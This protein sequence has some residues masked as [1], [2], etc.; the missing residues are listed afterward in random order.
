[1]IDFRYHLVSIVAIFLALSVGIVLG[2]TLLKEPAI[3]AAETLAN[4]LREGNTALRDDLQVLQKRGAAN[5]ALIV[6][7]TPKLVKDEL[8]GK[9]VV[10]VEAPGTTA[11]MR[12]AVQQVILEAGATVTG[13]V[14]LA[15]RYVD[16][17]QSAFV[18]KLATAAKPAEMIFPVAGTAYD[19]AA[20]VLASA[21][22]TSDPAQVGKEDPAAAEVL[23][24][25]QRGGLLTVTDKPAEHADLAVLTAPAEP[26]VGET[27]AEQAIAAEQAG[28]IVAMA[29]GLDEAGQGAV[30]VG[31]QSAAAAGGTITALREDTS[32]EERVSTVDTADMPAGRVVV[33]YALREQLSG[34]AGQYGIGPGASGVEPSATPAPAATT[35]TSGG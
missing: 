29:L 8:I 17:G 25:F 24:A 6:A 12:E 20:A 26:Y 2:T 9:R 33:V 1:M 35:A 15:D 32:F 5:D 34:L 4:Q 21:I 3:D 16:V 19:K 28:A 13:R 31:P 14:A 22:L 11:T 23:D 10:I 30:L 7:D 27:A 18:D